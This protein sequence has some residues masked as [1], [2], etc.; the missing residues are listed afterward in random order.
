MLKTFFLLFSVCV[1]SL[2]IS[3]AQARIGYSL[4]EIQEEFKQYN[5]KT[6][7]YESG[8][9]ALVFEF[10]KVTWMYHLNKN[11][12]CTAF[13][14]VFY[15]DISFRDYIIHLNETRVPVSDTQWKE[16]TPNGVLSITL[17]FID[18]GTPFFHYT[19]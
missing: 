16:Y 17:H 6:E 19:P 18:S 11:N 8:N 3:T 10:E 1:L 14:I 4:S 12:V 2:G 7:H 15:D 5:S 9:S 13:S